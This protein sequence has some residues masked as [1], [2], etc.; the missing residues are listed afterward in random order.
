MFIPEDVL[1]QIREANSIV[2]IVSEYVTLKKSGQNFQA[3]CPF[4]Q[5]KT[6]SFVVSPEKEIFHCFGCGIGGNV[7]H[8]LMQIEKLTFPEAVNKL[9]RR[10]GISIPENSSYQAVKKDEK[11]VYYDLYQQTVE[12]Y[13]RCLKETAEGRLGLE[14]LKKRAIQDSTIE[15][16]KLG[17]APVSGTALLSAAQKKGYALDH[18]EKIGLIKRGTNGMYDWFRGRLIFPITDRQGRAVAF[19][20]R[21]LEQTDKA[22]PKYINSPESPIYTKGKILYGLSLAAMAVR[23]ENKIILCE[24][25]TD[26]IFLHQVGI[27]NAVGVLG[28][29]LTAD[30]TQLLSRHTEEVVLLFDSDPAGLAAAE[31]SIDLLWEKDIKVSVAILPEGLDVDEYLIRNGRDSFEKILKN[32]LPFFEFYFQQAAKQENLSSTE[33]RVACAKRV[34]PHLTKINNLVLQKEYTRYLAEKLFLD[35]QALSNELSRYR[36]EEKANPV[37]VSGFVFKTGNET[38]KKETSRANTERE[39]IQVLLVEP[40]WIDE[41]K[42]KISED[43]FTS[44]P[45]REIWNFLAAAEPEKRTLPYL[46]DNFPEPEISNVLSGLLENHFK[47]DNLRKIAESLVKNMQELSLKEK[48]LQLEKEYRLMLTGEK[49][50]DGALVQEYEKTIRQLKTKK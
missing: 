13:H 17:F 21:L 25:Y 6:P 11:Q 4:H 7:F 26:V 37:R 41:F 10:A 39:L 18:L 34:L 28:T 24:G 42:T 1:S 12:F 31:R 27:E 2:Q 15:K 9:A 48:K 22:L 38:V 36:K 46:L 50:L 40:K 14:Y 8:F 45:W 44:S 29:S 35:E 47:A 19:G 43:N 16:F 5:E 33:G 30:Q 49:K 23:R 3:R 32:N 20:A